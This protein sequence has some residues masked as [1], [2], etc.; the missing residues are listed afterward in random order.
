M[1]CLDLNFGLGYWSLFGDIGEIL[2]IEV[3]M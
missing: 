3:K 2:G 1:E